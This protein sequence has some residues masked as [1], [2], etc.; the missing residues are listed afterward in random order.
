MRAIIDDKPTKR[1]KPNFKN[2]TPQV[3]DLPIR[4]FSEFVIQIKFTF[5]F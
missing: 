2:T 4:Q 3:V 1:E 5:F